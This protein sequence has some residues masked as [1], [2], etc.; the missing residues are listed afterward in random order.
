MAR[1]SGKTDSDGKLQRLGEA[2]RSARS[3]Q[4]YSQE[5][6]ADAVGIDRSHIG[7]IE[8]GE[9]N[10]SFLNVARIAVALNITVAALAQSAKL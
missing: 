9:R 7:K 6:F 2:I 5:A 4:G 3:A 8:R 1:Q 10:V